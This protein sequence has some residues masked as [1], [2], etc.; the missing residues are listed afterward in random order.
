[1]SNRK[2]MSRWT[3]S[4]LACAAAGLTL[5]AAAAPVTWAGGEFTWTQP[6]NDSFNA[7]YNSGDDVTFGA[8]GVGAITLGS[9]VTPGSTLF[10]AT[11]YNIKGSITDAFNLA[12][13]GALTINP[14][15][16]N[17]TAFTDIHVD[18]QTDR[19]RATFNGGT[20]VQS[21]TLQLRLNVG[22]AT[23]NTAHAVSFGTGAITLEN[24][25]TLRMNGVSGSASNSTYLLQN[26]I[27][28]NGSAEFNV[29]RG[30]GPVG[31]TNSGNFS[32]RLAGQVN[33]AGT[34]NIVAS[35]G[36]GGAPNGPHGISGNIV[37]NQSAAGTRA[38]IRGSGEGNQALTF[39]GNIVDGAGAAG[40]TLLI[41]T[42]G[43]ESTT[44]QLSILGT[45]NTYSADTTIGAAATA[46][47]ATNA[48]SGLQRAVVVGATSSLGTGDVDILAGG[49][50]T[51]Q[52]AGN[53]NS[54]AVLTINNNGFLHLTEDAD[55]VFN[56]L[57][58]V[59]AWNTTAND[60][61]ALDAGTYTVA[62]LNNFFGT[63]GGGN[64]TFHGLGSITVIPEPA[65]L[66]LMGLG[67]VLVL[68]GR[69]RG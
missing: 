58:S 5:P 46:A 31:G 61:I 33:L 43:S 3:H 52:G 13:N 64:A 12:G 42:N 48:A 49:L 19:T 27:N 16:S 11:G 62:E 35:G 7:T 55:L 47:T 54:N 37:I 32:G 9:A 34:L 22:A 68:G 30:A 59:F 24:G 17:Y 21:G 53:I 36:G 14:G 4:L 51:L 25:S 15:A 67:S 63:N 38:I 8:A 65:S 28:V 23:A 66:V 6:D 18:S 69:R 39:T 44:R 10:S 40:N 57:N 20:T 2:L 29:D 1:M 50:L 41:R 45:A 56:S 26:T 60:L